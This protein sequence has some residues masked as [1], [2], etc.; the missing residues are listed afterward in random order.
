MK[1]YGME[2]LPGKPGTP[3]GTPVPAQWYITYPFLQILCGD[4]VYDS[5]QQSVVSELL[6]TSRHSGY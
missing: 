2:L 5:R 3:A 6:A 1:V 4:T